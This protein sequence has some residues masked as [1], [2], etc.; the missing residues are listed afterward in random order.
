MLVLNDQEVFDAL[1]NVNEL[2]LSL[3][4]DMPGRPYSSHTTTETLYQFL[5]I[6]KNKPSFMNLVGVA[7]VAYKLDKEKF[8]AFFDICSER[9]DKSYKCITWF[10]VVMVLFILQY[11]SNNTELY[12]WAQFHLNQ[13]ISKNR[14][15]VPYLEQLSSVK[16]APVL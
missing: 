1:W 16:I 11:T 15:I 12:G 4:L 13:L 2:V 10:D 7:K 3:N 14:D 5:S 9:L 6:G 8:D